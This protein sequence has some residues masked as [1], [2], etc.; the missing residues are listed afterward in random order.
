[1]IM[2][3]NIIIANWKMHLD[4]K[5]SV[6]Q[7]KILKKLVEENNIKKDIEIVICPDFLSLNEV[8]KIFKNTNIILG[9]QDGF[10]VEKG[11]YTGE[12]SMKELH[13]LNCRYI[14]LGHSERRKMGE[15]DEDINKKVI[16]ALDYELTP[17]IC[18]GERFN[19]R[20]E[21]LKDNVIMHQ[22]YQAL[23]DVKL[24]KN[25]NIIIAYE[26]VWVIGSGQ[27]IDPQEA[28]HTALVIQQSILD[29]LGDNANK[30]SRVIYGGSVKKENVNKFTKLRNID[31]ALVGG[32]SLKS[33][34]FLELIKQV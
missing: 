21:G 15:T 32:A 30:N 2:Y 11:S 17:I 6:E 10:Y 9:A 14:I 19:E 31:G 16:S 29:M 3:K 5:E 18:V 34:E 23:K 26:P 28:T 12:V 13:D 33:A 4:L 27:V 25:Q 20:R 22:V 7:A 24:N 1:M 8:G